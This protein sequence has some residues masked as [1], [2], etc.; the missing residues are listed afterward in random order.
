MGFDI[1]GL[2]MKL[3]WFGLGGLGMRLKWPIVR[4]AWE[5]AW[6]ERPGKWLG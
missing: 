4:M 2:G 6:L 1:D 3:E 5:M